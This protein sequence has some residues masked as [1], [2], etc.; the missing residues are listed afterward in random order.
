ML[1]GWQALI[2][3]AV[4]FTPLRTLHSDTQLSHTSSTDIGCYQNFL[5]PISEPL[6]DGGSLLHREFPTQQGHLV[7]V[8]HHLHSQPLGIATGLGEKEQQWVKAG[9]LSL[10]C[11]RVWGESCR[12]ILFSPSLSLARSLRLWH[13]IL[14]N[15]KNHI[16][17]T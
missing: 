2:L 11:S 6:D 15:S 5:F 10:G 16:L 4:V 9:W 3:I 14:C 13:G 12:G 1:G 17:S 8:L 7:A